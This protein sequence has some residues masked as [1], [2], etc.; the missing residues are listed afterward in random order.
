M[1]RFIDW[2][3]RRI[4][5]LFGGADEEP[6]DAELT[7]IN[8]TLDQIEPLVASI[9]QNYP[10]TRLRGDLDHLKGLLDDF[11]GISKEVSSLLS[12][13]I[14]EAELFE[15]K[16]GEQKKEFVIKA[17]MELYRRH[18]LDLPHIPEFLERPLLELLLNIAIDYT[19]TLF[20][21]NF[22]DTWIQLAQKPALPVTLPQPSAPQA[23]T[24]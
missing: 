17:F 6:D 21:I 12:I 24:S 15:D 22:G 14:K 20:D 1:G 7:E 11:G 2:V 16:K 3:T 13:L 4:R 18:H 5:R 10:I 19:I 8:Q 9:I 23:L